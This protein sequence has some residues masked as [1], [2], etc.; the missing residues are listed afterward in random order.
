MGNKT[1]NENMGKTRRR[2]DRAIQAVERAYIWTAFP[3]ETAGAVVITGFVALA[4]AHAWVPGFKI[5]DQGRT[6][7][8]AAAWMLAAIWVYMLYAACR[9]MESGTEPETVRGWKQAAGHAALVLPLALIASGIVMATQWDSPAVE[10]AAGYT[11]FAGLAL[12]AL[13]TGAGLAAR[14]RRKLDRRNG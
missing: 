10:T 6:T 13:R 1:V 11:L 2:I 4:L 14:I 5:P 9:Y 3:A 8:A 7:D 12:A